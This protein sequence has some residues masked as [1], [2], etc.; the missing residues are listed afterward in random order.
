MKSI[1]VLTSGG[2][3]PGMNPCIRAVVRTA[4]F[5]GKTVF[6]IHDGYKGL[7]EGKIEPLEA[8]SVGGILQQGGTM[9]GTARSPEMYTDEGQAKAA[10]IFKA[11]GIEGLVVIGGDGSMRGAQTMIKHGLNVI[12]VPGS[13]D[14]DIWGTNMS[15]G[16]DTAL[17]T[18]QD[19]VDK[20]RDTASSHRR[21]FIV[22]VMGRN[23]GYLAVMAGINSG[24]EVVLIPEVES[25]VEEVAESIEGAYYRGKRHSIVMV[26]EG[27]NV[28]AQDLANR[29]KEM[30]VGFH[31]RV[32]ILGHIQ[33]GGS[34]T[35]FDRMLATRMGVKAAE[36]LIAGESN[37]MV[38][39]RGR[40]MELVSLD[41]VISKQREAN[42][43]YYEMCK[44]LAF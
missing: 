37:S 11:S 13:I 14:N 4:L 25:S 41:E 42:L 24:A 7:L 9:L 39:L 40:S 21:A 38:A 44:M 2:D 1:A 30:T 16:T 6:G 32:T 20:L 23:C 19:A 31:T 18:I 35:A 15:I 3:A 33:R 43:E 26:A 29:L 8:R 22:E 28:K 12:G 10:K 27:S 36:V 17:N 5:N 34:P